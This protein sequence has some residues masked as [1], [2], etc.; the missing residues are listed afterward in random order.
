MVEIGGLPIL[1]HI[2]MH[3]RSY[4][5]T[6]FVVALGYKGDV[7]KRYFVDRAQLNGSMRVD[8]AGGKIS[9]YDK[10]SA[11]WRV[12]L[13][14]TGEKTNTGGRVKRLAPY[15]GNETFML[16]WGD[17]VSNVDLAALLA[18]HRRHGKAMTV[19][20]VR[21]PARFGHLIFDGDRV[22]DFQEKPAA[23]EGWIN[24][25]FF[26]VEPR[27]L[28]YIA[29]DETSWEHG[30]MRALARE[31]ELVA[32]RHEGFWQCMDTVRERKL[33]EDLWAAGNPPWKVW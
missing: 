4:G 12:D 5:H 31:G 32:F 11:E 1:W 25:A 16:T 17:G 28:D 6:D 27:V 8:L 7:I 13:I 15:L 19:T 30:P 10:P 23:S 21:P 22:I 33:L 20:A 3:Y 29:D 14:E 2:M 18:F 26:V 24:G 9:A